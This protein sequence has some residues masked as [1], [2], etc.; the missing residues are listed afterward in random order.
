MTPQEAQM[1]AA[2]ALSDILSEHEVAHAFIGGFAVNVLGH[3]RATR[4]VDVEIDVADAAELR[5]RISQLLIERDARFSQV[6]IKL[7]FTP[8]NH[9][10]LRVPIETLPIGE[11]GLPR[12]LAVIQLGDS[13]SKFFAPSS[14]LYGVF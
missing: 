1:Q 12:R 13:L 5:G 6:N 10:E 11:L 14:T 8:T 7:F 9:P 2:Q 4:D 3:N